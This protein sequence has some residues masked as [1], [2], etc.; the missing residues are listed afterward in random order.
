MRMSTS[1]NSEIFFGKIKYNFHCEDLLIQYFLI[2]I[3]KQN[4][5]TS[6][7]WPEHTVIT[8][9]IYYRNKSS[10]CIRNMIT[11]TELLIM[12][13]VY[14]GVSLVWKHRIRIIENKE[15]M[16]VILTV[17]ITKCHILWNVT[18]YLTLLISWVFF[19]LFCKSYW[20]CKCPHT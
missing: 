19:L 17:S 4:T 12:P 3:I 13:T 15:A 9:Q 20:E 5:G 7:L 11:L 14:K 16:E 18:M 6:Y 8:V 10:K 2:L 1:R